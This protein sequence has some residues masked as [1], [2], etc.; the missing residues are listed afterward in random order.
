MQYPINLTLI[1]Q[2]RMLRLNTLQLD[3]NFL[4]GG[5]VGTEVDVAEGT[6]TDLAAE[7]VLLA[8]AELHCGWGGGRGGVRTGG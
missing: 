3:S 7:A 4:T 5:H 8:D 1:K 6:G 2:L